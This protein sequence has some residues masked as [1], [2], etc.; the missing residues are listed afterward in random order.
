MKRILI[1]L[2]ISLLPICVN[3]QI[4]K[5][6]GYIYHEKD[7]NGK[8]TSK[9]CNTVVTMLLDQENDIVTVAC[10]KKDGSLLISYFHIEEKGTV[11]KAG[12]QRYAAKDL[13]DSEYLI[14]GMRTKGD[15]Y[16]DFIVY[17]DDWAI[18]FLHNLI[19]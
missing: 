2:I 11:N 18:E 13:L 1:S 17:H 14:V 8:V 7:A 12:Y 4:C 6:S 3:A 19:I 10:E 5:G 16:I 9:T 15:G